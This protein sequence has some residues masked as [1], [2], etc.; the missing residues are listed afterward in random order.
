[1]STKKRDMINELK[2]LYKIREKYFESR[3]NDPG[4]KEAIDLRLLD[5]GIRELEDEFR[6]QKVSGTFIYQNKFL[7]L[8]TLLTQLLNKS[9]T[10]RII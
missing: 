7:K 10:K 8:L 6:N 2:S 4:S 9:N 5:N 3:F 1:M